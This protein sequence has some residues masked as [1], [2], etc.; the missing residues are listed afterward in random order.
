MGLFE[1][2]GYIPSANYEY[3][4]SYG[5]TTLSTIPDLR[6]DLMMYGHE[7]ADTEIVLHAT[8]I[9]TSNPF[10]D[11]LSYAMIPMCYYPSLY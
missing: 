7:E 11:C 4:I 6:K 3:A 1:K 5:N 2:G 10:R 8:D 9:S